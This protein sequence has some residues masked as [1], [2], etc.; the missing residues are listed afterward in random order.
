VSELP[1]L[2]AEELSCIALFPLPRVTLFPGTTL[3][4]HV[5]E[6][7]YRAMIADCVSES[8]MQFVVVQLRPGH[9]ASYE[10][11][12]PIYD[13]GGAGRITA[14]RENADGTYDIRVEASCRVALTEL[15]P[16]DK[17]YRRARAAALP[18]ESA[19]HRPDRN[20]LSALW[21]LAAQVTELVRK[22][23]GVPVRLLGSASEEAG[24]L[25]DGVADQLI[26]DPLL[27]QRLL[28]TLDVNAR[29]ALTKGYLA[30]LH[31]ALLQASKDSPG[32]LH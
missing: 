23:R 15:P 25:V 13:V 4:L 19:D 6:P 1:S 14:C 30:K 3:A 5:F 21:S 29:L 22:Q 26:A 20:E 11:R 8:S 10:G 18:V 2:R 16:G 27:R 12:P 31:L 7:R 17:A 9:E 24:R 32:T 28:E